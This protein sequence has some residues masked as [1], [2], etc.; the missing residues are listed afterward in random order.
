M[1]SVKTSVPETMSYQSGF[2][3]SSSVSHDTNNNNYD[4]SVK[5]FEIEGENNIKINGGGGVGDGDG[6]SENEE[7]VSGDEGFET[8]S[9][10]PVV[11][12]ESRE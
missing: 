1:D 10:K 6:L 5:N 11:A 9:E 12:E 4:S 7:F 2:S 8:T 3:A